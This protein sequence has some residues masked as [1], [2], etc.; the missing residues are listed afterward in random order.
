MTTQE[1]SDQ[2]MYREFHSMMFDFDT[3]S[4]DLIRKGAHDAVVERALVFLRFLHDNVTQEDA[5]GDSVRGLVEFHIDTITEDYTNPEEAAQVAR[6][7]VRLVLKMCSGFLP[8]AQPEAPRA[9]A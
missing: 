1:M 5:I 4:E 6:N 8:D 7:G 9:Q 3:I 2:E